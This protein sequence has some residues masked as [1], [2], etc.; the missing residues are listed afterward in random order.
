MTEHNISPGKVHVDGI[1]PAPSDLPQV[2]VI[3]DINANGIV[4]VSAL[5]ESV[6]LETQTK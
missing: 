1:P 6:C 2:E 3:F 4:T 5:D